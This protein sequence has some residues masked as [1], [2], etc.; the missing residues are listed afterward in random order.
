MPKRA[1]TIGIALRS[2][3]K[4]QWSDGVGKI[5]NF[6]IQVMTIEQ[7]CF[8]QQRLGLLRQAAYAVDVAEVPSDVRCAKREVF[9]AAECKGARK[10]LAHLLEHDSISIRVFYAEVLETV[11]SEFWRVRNQPSPTNLF[12]RGVDVGA[13]NIKSRIA[14]NHRARDIRMFWA[15]S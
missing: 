2:L 6:R 11:R 4:C 14:V 7:Y 12:I 5:E 3:K 9:V 15:L 1:R 13:A 8:R 10:S